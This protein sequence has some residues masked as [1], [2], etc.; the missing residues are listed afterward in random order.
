MPETNTIIEKKEV[1]IGNL[2]NGNGNPKVKIIIH[3]LII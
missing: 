2:I 1:D 3:Y